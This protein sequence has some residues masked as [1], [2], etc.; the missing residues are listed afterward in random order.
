MSLLLTG[1]YVVTMDDAGTEHENGWVLVEDG[2]VQAVGDGPPP[3]AE[4]VER[5]NGALVTPG[6]VNTHHHLYQ[7]LTRTRAQEA[8][9]FTWLKT[10][11]PLWGRIDAESEYAAARTGLAELALSGC[12][13][14]FDHH[15]VFPPG[16]EGIVEAEVQAARELGVRIVASRGSMDLGESEGGL[17]PDSLVEDGD[18]ALAATEALAATLHE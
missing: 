14:V 10:L 18:A 5:L 2:F 9:L 13:T 4:R 12:S 11:Y 7:T 8:D 16:R 1:G 3:K 17:P 6:L 15:Y